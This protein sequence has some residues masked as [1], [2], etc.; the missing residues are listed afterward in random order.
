MAKTLRWLLIFL[1]VGA[2]SELSATQ[3]SHTVTHG[4]IAYFGFPSPFTIERFD[5]ETASFLPPLPLSGSITA[6]AVDDDAVYVAYTTGVVSR[7]EHTGGETTLITLPT[8]ASSMVLDGPHLF[9]S[10]GGTVHSLDKVTGAQIDEIGVFFG[11]GGLS[12]APMANRMFG[13]S[14]GV[15]PSDIMFTS[16]NDQGALLLADDSQYHADYPGGNRTWVLPGDTHVVDNSGTIYTTDSLTYAGS[17]GPFFDDLTSTDD[18]ILVSRGSTLARY[19][20]QFAPEG[21]LNLSQEPGNISVHGE[22]LFIFRDGVTQLVDVEQL[23]LSS[24]EPPQA[25]PPVNPVGLAFTPDDIEVG[26]DGTI[27]LLSITHKNIFRWSAPSEEWLESIPLIDEPIEMAYSPV[28]DRLYISHESGIIRQVEPSVST[29]ESYFA[30]SPQEPL[31]L[32]TAD[33]YVFVCD[34]TGAWESHFTYSPE[35][36]LISQEEWN[37]YSREYTWS[38]ANG[39]IY[40]FRDGTSPNDIYWEEIGTDGVLGLQQDSPFHSSNGIA[41]PIRVHPNGSVV[42]LGSGR[43]YNAFTLDLIDELG[44]SLID[45]TWFMDTLYTLHGTAQTEWQSWFPTYVSNE[46]ATLPGEPQRIL[47][48]GNK[49][50]VVSLV[51]GVPNFTVLAELPEMFQRGD[52]NSDGDLDVAD[53]VYLALALFAGE[54]SYSIGCEDAADSN[55]DE[56]LNLADVIYTLTYVLLSGPAPTDVGVCSSELSGGED[57]LNCELYMGP[58]P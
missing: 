44:T 16:Y 43:V 11:I 47:N 20:T 39:R 32:A 37:H 38:A 5:L 23:P 33:Q 58:C 48:T 9:A 34:A 41:P 36:E 40:H 51:A 25:G 50:V 42:L 29:V 54:S 17:L 4:G 26:N 46:T 3:W 18:L 52:V 10:R 21:T 31:G 24:I 35:G 12:I 22:Q 6:L 19:S 30:T 2:A 49:L 27:Y 45:A 15:S 13:R 56:I 55:D 53:G 7:I 8:P 14:I 28:T 57:V 1:T